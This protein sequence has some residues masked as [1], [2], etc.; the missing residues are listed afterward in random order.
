MR[1]SII[2][3]IYNVEQYIRSCVESIFR[4]SMEDNEFEVILVNDGTP[5]NSFG[6]V[7]DII[8]QHKNVSIVEQS[9]Q[10]LSVARNTGLLYAKGEYVLF[11]DSDDLLVD[12]TLPSLLALSEH[13]PDLIVAGFKKM[14][15]EEIDNFIVPTLDDVVE[16]VKMGR[17]LFLKDLNP[18]QCYVWRT[19]YRKAFLEK[20]K[21]FALLK[22]K[23]FSPAQT[24]T[25][26]LFVAVLGRNQKG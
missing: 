25:D 14:D 11:L 12:N 2:V 10:G 24:G 23:Q 1:L 3:P 17:E 5:D 9:N 18:Q 26:G 13:M 15:N 22:E 4:Q 8:S 19:L 20:N 16:E 7:E 6:K 21:D